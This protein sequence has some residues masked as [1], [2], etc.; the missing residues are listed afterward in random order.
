MPKLIQLFD[1][2]GI[3]ESWRSIKPEF[4]FNSIFNLNANNEYTSYLLEKKQLM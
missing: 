3:T 2:N 4:D 1:N